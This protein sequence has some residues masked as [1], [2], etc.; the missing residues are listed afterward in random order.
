[1]CLENGHWEHGPV[2]GFGMTIVSLTLESHAHRD[3][4]AFKLHQI[5]NSQINL[6]PKSGMQVLSSIL[7]Q[8]STDL[9]WII[10]VSS[11]YRES[12]SM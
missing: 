10:F 5:E 7:Y 3:T 6:F 2:L 1:M 9:S 11:N 12:I 8:K 4:K